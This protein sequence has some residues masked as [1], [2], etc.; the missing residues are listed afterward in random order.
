MTSCIPLGEQ[1][2]E[3]I[4]ELSRDNGDKQVVLLAHSMGTYASEVEKNL[5]ELINSA[6]SEK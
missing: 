1:L 6:K 4:E 3:T 2:C 5:S